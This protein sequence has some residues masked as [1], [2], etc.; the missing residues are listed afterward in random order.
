MC[1][2]AGCSRIL[3]QA[4]STIRSFPK[5]SL[6]ESHKMERGGARERERERSR[7]LWDTQQ[8][9]IF[10]K[11]PA[12]KEGH[13]T[14]RRPTIYVPRTGF[15]RPDNIIGGGFRLTCANQLPRIVQQFLSSGHDSI[16]ASFYLRG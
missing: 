15:L 3:Q 6:P 10:V 4:R 14:E 2:F 11:T 9:A 13:R 7:P 12:E 5:K 8:E 16:P 1:G